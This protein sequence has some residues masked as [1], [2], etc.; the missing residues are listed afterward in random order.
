M[1]TYEHHPKT[2][3]DGGSRFSR[4]GLAPPDNRAASATAA[5]TR[6]Y[7][8]GPAAMRTACVHLLPR[9]AS[10][11]LSIRRMIASGE[12][13]PFLQS[14]GRVVHGASCK[15]A[16]HVVKEDGAVRSVCEQ[17]KIDEEK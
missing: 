10:S 13:L 4:S 14:V 3:I 11:P 15:Y 2:S 6:A 12:S 16:S 9:T 1:Q 17:S 5:S 8:S 7:G